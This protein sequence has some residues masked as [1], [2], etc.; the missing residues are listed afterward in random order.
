[1]DFL[2]NPFWQV[3]DCSND[4]IRVSPVGEWHRGAISTRWLS[5][6]VIPTPQVPKSVLAPGMASISCQSSHARSLSH[7]N[8]SHPRHMR[9]SSGWGE[10]R[11]KKVSACLLFQ[12]LVQCRLPLSCW[13]SSWGYRAIVTTANNRKISTLGLFA[14]ALVVSNSL[15]VSPIYQYSKINLKLM[16]LSLMT[17]CIIL[18]TPCHWS[19]QMC[20]SP[21]SHPHP[22]VSTWAST[23]CV[24]VLL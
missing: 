4:V 20:P 9:P 17:L 5:F 1:M 10:W 23:N 14:K 2:N 18:S 11:S 6:L 22:C 19:H 16:C 8:P 21:A 12:I 3:P 15:L 7:L 24:C 13:S